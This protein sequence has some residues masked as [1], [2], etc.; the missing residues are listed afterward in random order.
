[1]PNTTTAKQYWSELQKRFPSLDVYS[2]YDLATAKRN[3]RPPTTAYFE[4]WLEN[5]AADFLPPPPDEMRVKAW[6]PPTKDKVLSYCASK[7]WPVG[8]GRHAWSTFVA[9]DWKHYGEPI[10]SDDQWQAILDVMEW[11][12]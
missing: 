3:G 4:A 2:E 7:K 6:C 10:K 8:F 9:N 12:P 5:A 11:N 1:M